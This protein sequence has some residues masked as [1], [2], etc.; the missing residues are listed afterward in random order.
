MTLQVDGTDVMAAIEVAIWVGSIVAMLVIGFIVYLMVRPARR[1]AEAPPPEDEALDARELLRLMDRMER[2]LEMLER[3]V[4]AEARDGD[5]IL[6]AG[7]GAPETR[8]TK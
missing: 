7:D 2:R 5:R 1:R 4:G 6:E 8:R 3:A